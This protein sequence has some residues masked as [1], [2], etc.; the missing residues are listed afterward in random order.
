MTKTVTV[1]WGS[2]WMGSSPSMLLGQ[3]GLS[4]A[5]ET[6]MNSPV[7]DKLSKALALTS[8]NDVKPQAQSLRHGSPTW[9]LRGFSGTGFLMPPSQDVARC[10]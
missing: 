6:R 9:H 3:A 2:L 10:V 4:C 5:R 8:L 1:G 7:T